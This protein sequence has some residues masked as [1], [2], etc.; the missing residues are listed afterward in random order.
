MVNLPGSSLYMLFILCFHRWLLRYVVLSHVIYFSTA[1][2]SMSV[3][4][5]TEVIAK[6]TKIC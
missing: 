1:A 4:V 3:R 6:D 2:I 5:K